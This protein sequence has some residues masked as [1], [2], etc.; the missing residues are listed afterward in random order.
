[1]WGIFFSL[2]CRH[3]RCCWCCCDWRTW[4]YIWNFLPNHQIGENSECLKPFEMQRHAS[5]FNFLRT[6]FMQWTPFA[7]WA[8]KTVC[9]CVQCAY[10]CICVHVYV[11]FFSPLSTFSRC[12][13][14]IRHMNLC[15]TQTRYRCYFSCS[16]S[17]RWTKPHVC[18]SFNA[19]IFLVFPYRSRFSR[20]VVV[21]ITWRE[22][23][24]LFTGIIFY[25]SCKL[26][27][28]R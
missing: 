9:M 19:I 12:I 5:R 27:R 20:S 8:F 26:F 7:I 1:M 16:Q 25:F 21:Y 2:R 6:D 22:K 23:K 28:A 24:T 10:L 13:F 14:R 18:I 3:C 4:K 17:A 15:L 11:C